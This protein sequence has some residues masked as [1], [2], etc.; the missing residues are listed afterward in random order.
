MRL[1]RQAE[2]A[3]SDVL[4]GDD[5]NIQEDGFHRLLDDTEMDKRITPSVLLATRYKGEWALKLKSVRSLP[6]K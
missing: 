6:F 3:E 4:S 2:I 5:V 1:F